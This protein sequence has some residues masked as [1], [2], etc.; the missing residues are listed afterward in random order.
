MTA[1]SPRRAVSKGR[2]K[3]VIAVIANSRRASAGRRFLTDGNLLKSAIQGL[4]GDVM[5]RLVG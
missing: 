4:C 1:S 5:G 2:S 3:M